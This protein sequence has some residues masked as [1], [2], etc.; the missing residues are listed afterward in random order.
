MDG[1]FRKQVF[2]DVHRRGHRVVESR[3]SRRQDRQM[4]EGK[5]R[6]VGDILL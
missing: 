1:R 6:R 5:R 4:G 3:R 2:N